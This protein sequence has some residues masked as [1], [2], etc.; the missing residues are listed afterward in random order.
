KIPLD[1][2]LYQE[3][4][5]RMLTRSHPDEAR[6]LLREA[7]EDVYTRWHFYEYLAARK[8][9]SPKADDGQAVAPET[10]DVRPAVSR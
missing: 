4:R 6:R 8:I 10:R 2:Y 5:F 9:E 7:Q 1:E 3:N